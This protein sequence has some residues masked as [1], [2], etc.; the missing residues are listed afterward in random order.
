MKPEFITRMEEELTQLNERRSK[1]RSLIESPAFNNLD[2]LS[3]D[4]LKI[5]LNAMDIYALSLGKRYQRLNNEYLSG[6]RSTHM[7]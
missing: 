6:A 7:D 1:L 4:D 2:E 3:K 5:Q